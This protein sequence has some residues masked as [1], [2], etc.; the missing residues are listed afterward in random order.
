MQSFVVG[1]ARLRL[2]SK[3]YNKKMYVDPI[4][5]MLLQFDFLIKHAA[6]RNIKY[7]PRVTKV[8]IVK[9]RLVP[10]NSVAKV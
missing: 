4:E 3:L 9:R 7:G 2:E 8:Y 1:P 5:D 10:P 6:N